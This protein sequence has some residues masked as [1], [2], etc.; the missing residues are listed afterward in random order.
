MKIVHIEPKFV[1]YAD[2]VEDEDIHL[3]KEIITYEDG[4]KV[5]NFRVVKDFKRPFYTDIRYNPNTMWFNVNDKDKH[6]PDKRLY[7][8][9]KEYIESKYTKE[10]LTTNKKLWPAVAIALG[11][12]PKS[13]GYKYAWND[14]PYLYGTDIPSETYLMKAYHK[15]YKATT[16]LTKLGVLDLEACTETGEVFINSTGDYDGL[17]LVLNERL[18]K[19][20]KDKFILD[21][22][23]GIKEMF[24]DNP[25][26]AKEGYTL[27]VVYGDE[28]YVIKDGIRW[29]HTRDIDVVGIWNMNYDIPIIEKRA[30][31]LN[32][33][34]KT[35]W[36][37]PNLD[38]KYHH[39]HF[40]EGSKFKITSG[41]V[42]MNKPPEE[43]WSVV[44]IA[45]HW[46]IMDMMTVYKAARTAE[47][48][49]SGGYSLGNIANV[50]LGTGKVDLAVDDISAKLVGAKLHDYMAHNKFLEYAIYAAGDILV[51]L[52]LDMKTTDLRIKLS[53]ISATSPWKIFNSNPSRLNIKYNDFLAKNGYIMGN[54]VSKKYI[55]REDKLLGREDWVRTL[56]SAMRDEPGAGLSNYDG[57]DYR[58]D[59]NVT[60]LDQEAGYPSNAMAVGYGRETTE[61]ELKYVTNIRPETSKRCNR[62]LV[63]GIANHLEYAEDMFK[64]PRI[65][66]VVEQY[67]KEL[68]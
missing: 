52:W 53:N 55:D 31:L 25:V 68:T 58:M 15:K 38:S 27:D 46:Q 67:E 62:G 61:R 66:K 65:D 37:N 3:V 29:L 26:F 13:Y 8:E 42:R 64:L 32:I 63:Y 1:I 50:F 4:S 51:P 28:S 11:K 41:G 16:S 10:T 22:K 21:V 34:L 48:K 44:T 7:R 56:S 43:I 36:S 6:G 12:N 20:D 39:Y 57:N 49:Q 47:P 19:G 9:P 23:E 60:D 35:L 14:M 33:D 5:R 59:L 24:K 45:A 17:R 40:R 18:I 2:W 30:N 54:A